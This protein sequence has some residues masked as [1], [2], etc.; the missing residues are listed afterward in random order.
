MLLRQYLFNSKNALIECKPPP[1]RHLVLFCTVT[2]RNVDTYNTIQY[3]TIQ[4]NTI[5]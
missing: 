3:N 5:Q 4:Y 1:G 2:H